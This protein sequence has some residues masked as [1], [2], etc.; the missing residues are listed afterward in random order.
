[1][2]QGEGHR[3]SSQVQGGFGGLPGTPGGLCS[4]RWAGTSVALESGC[5]I[6]VPAPPQALGCPFAPLSLP[7][8]PAPAGV[9]TGMFPLPRPA[10]TPGQPRVVQDTCP[11]DVPLPHCLLPLVSSLTASLGLPTTSLAQPW[12]LP[13]HGS[14]AQC[15]VMAAAKGEP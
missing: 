10:L 7:S 12:L 15:W 13:S 9:S 11:P 14:A 1:M 8:A 6:P 5:H 4:C 3:T 2:L